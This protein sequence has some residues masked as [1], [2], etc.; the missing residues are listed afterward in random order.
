MSVGNYA[1]LGP[2][3]FEE[4]VARRLPPRGLAWPRQPGGVFQ[5]FWTAVANG[6]AAFHAREAVL[7]ETEAFPPT[8]VELL[9]PWEDVLGLPD[10]CLGP[11]PITSAR[12]AAVAARLA[13]TGGQSV[14]YFEQLAANLGGEITIT[15]YA[16]YRLGVDTCWAPLRNPSWAYVWLVTLTNEAAFAFEIGVSSCWEPLWQIAN[17]P[18][19]C[20]IQ[21]LSPAHTQVNFTL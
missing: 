16:P 6:L 7:T 2:A 5:G 15:E 3:D 8:S 9:S 21:R 4:A 19:Q 20:E 18:I 17:D 11:N 13:A 10:P 14:P 12:Q 1:Q